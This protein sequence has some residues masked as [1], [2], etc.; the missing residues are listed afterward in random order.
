M[1]ELEKKLKK[2]QKIKNFFD[3]LGIL[4][5]CI[6]P[7]LRVQE[8]YDGILIFTVLTIVL[9]IAVYYNKARIKQIKKEIQNNSFLILEN[10]IEKNYTKIN[11]PVEE[12]ENLE[13]EL[14]NIAYDKYY[15]EDNCYESYEIIEKRYIDNKRLNIKDISAF[16][17]KGHNIFLMT[18][19]E[20][21]EDF[22]DMDKNAKI[23]IVNYVFI[24]NMNKNLR[25]HINVD[26]SRMSDTN[27][28]EMYY[29]NEELIKENETV[30]YYYKVTQ[31]EKEIL[32][33]LYNKF[34]LNNS[35]V[36]KN[37]KLYIRIETLN[38]Y[39]DVLNVLELFMKEFELFIK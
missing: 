11:I 25:M 28:D 21:E 3:I 19:E 26:E 31:K 35:I 8:A 16:R 32:V 5:L 24:V 33:D 36:M 9:I 4:M 18:F 14:K 37:E 7:I 13:K 17:R 39:T 20:E 38:D 30:N 22:S 23:T 15:I 1:N 27:F 6:L 2:Y 29:D 12:F 10:E 34:K